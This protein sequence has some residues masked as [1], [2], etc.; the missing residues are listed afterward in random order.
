MTADTAASPP[1]P[2]GNTS[3]GAVSELVA[4]WSWCFTR[5]STALAATLAFCPTLWLLLIAIRRHFFPGDPFYWNHEMTLTLAFTTAGATSLFLARLLNR[6]IA[7]LLAYHPDM[8]DL[9]A[10]LRDR[11][12]D[13]RWLVPAPLLLAIVAISIRYITALEFSPFDSMRLDILFSGWLLAGFFFML[14]ATV[15]CGRYTELVRRIAHEVA[16]GKLGRV[17]TGL[18]SRFYL[19][20][21][22]LATV[23][24]GFCVIIIYTLHLVYTYRGLMWPAYALLRWRPGLNLAGQLTMLLKD[25][26][27]FELAIFFGLLA[28]ASLAPLLYFT[29]PQWEVHKL[30][31][32]RRQALLTG[33]RTRLDEIERRLTPDAP[34]AEFDLF[35]R[36]RNAVRAIE[37]MPT[38]PFAGYGTLG[39][40][41]LI[42]LP[43][44]LVLI[45]EVFLQAL[46]QLLF[47]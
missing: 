40:A 30:L 32:A 25:P 9:L 5:F 21:A 41:L 28:L 14:N 46:I 15:L 1:P 35:D 3:V 36:R 37:E 8:L 19:K 45:K 43:G 44:I 42:A 16:V 38:W 7:D 27:F 4:P 24:F 6:L 13:W 17:E 34:E 39:T 33:A 10:G 31:D 11:F 47:S 18:L 23:H 2:R 22:V 26:L 29:Y 12:H 20:V